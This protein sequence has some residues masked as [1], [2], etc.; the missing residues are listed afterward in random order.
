MRLKWPNNE[1]VVG[2]MMRSINE[3]SEVFQCLP[4]LIGAWVGIGITYDTV[5]KT[6]HKEV[7]NNSDWISWRS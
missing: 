7:Y 2:K 6:P 1:K 3:D 4:Y 5:L